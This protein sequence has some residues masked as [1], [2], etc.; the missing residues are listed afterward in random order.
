MLVSAILAIAQD[1]TMF[2]LTPAGGGLPSQAGNAGE[3]LTTNGTNASWL[4]LAGG[5][6]M[7]G[8]NN[9]S[10]I[11]S[12]S[13][14]RIE[15]GLVIGTNVQAWDA[16][17]DIYAGINPSANIQT[18]L[19]AA[20]YAAM[21]TQLGIAI[22]AS[23]FDGNLATTDDTIQEIAQKLDDLIAVGGGGGTWGSITGTLSAQTD[24]Q[25]ALD[26]K[27]PLDSDLTSIASLTTTTFGRGLLDEVDAT[28][29]RGTIG[30]DSLANFS[31]AIGTGGT[32]SGSTFLRG[33]NTWAVPAGA[34][35]VTATGGAL[36]L[37][38]IVLGAGGTDTKALAS[39]GTTTTVLHGNA[40]G[41]PSFGAVSL[42]AD[43][44]GDLPL[45]NLVQ[46]TALSVL[47]VTGNATA[48]NAPIVAALDGQILRRSG[49]TVGFG[50]IDLANADAVAGILPRSL[51]GLG[52]NTSAY[53]IGLFGINS[54]GGTIH[55]NTLALLDDAIGLTGTANS[56]TFLRGDGAWTAVTASAP[57]SDTQ[58]VFNDGGILG[59]DAG[60]LYN[61]TTD[62]ATFVN[63]SVTG[64]MTAATLDAVTFKVL[65]NVDQS[66]GVSIVA[67]ENLA[68]NVNLNLTLG[69]TR[70]LSIT[71]NSVLSG[72]NT[73]DQT[74]AGPLT[75]D[76]SGFDGNLA[77]TD[78]TVQEVAQ[79]L[80][81]LAAG[82]GGAPTT[83]N[84]LVGTADAGLSAAI[85]VGTTPGGELGG[86]W[87]SPT[88][89]DSLTVDLWTLTTPTLTTPRFADLGYIADAAGLELLVFDSVASAVNEARLGNAAT[90]SNPFL[91]A[92]G[93]DSNVGIDFLTKGDGT[94]RMLGNPTQS[95]RMKFLEDSDNGTNSITL[96]APAS[97]TTDSSIT[98]PEIAADTLVGKITTDVFQN[99][100]LS[101]ANNTL[102][103]Q[104]P[105]ACSD[106]TTA[107]TAGT[108]KAYWRPPH[109]CTIVAVEASAFTAPT[110]ANV[111]ID[112]NESGTTILSTKLMVEAT[113]KTSRTAVTPYVISDAAIADNAEVT[114][115]FDQVG[116]TVAGAGI[117]VTIIYT[118]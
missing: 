24:L 75:V 12:P 48:D 34:G 72:T 26:A 20:N 83:V 113:E 15:L 47:G 16:Q 28:S 40:A 78:N 14:A 37:N 52:A 93:G 39:L 54:G 65:D 115:D 22:D 64:A 84:Y 17:L 81:D 56:S 101:N 59:A 116:S 105:I 86:S 45:A 118:Y 112:I 103:Q 109:A 89:D 41:V 8:A 49:T 10:E 13:A 99:K 79:K 44:S 4:P 117:I 50:A 106:M 69:A 42:T 62:T 53:G 21:R 29:I 3:F 1:T 30:L 107:I 73:G 96:L 27:Q 97:I 76:A 77:T 60:A 70:S 57:G 110:G 87:A 108:N 80:D 88:I 32:P 7:V 6:D 98:L 74:A 2:P 102:P 33:D 90:G 46:G 19:G 61:K 23:G 111:L 25:A 95:G 67:N 114:I 51:G 66:H 43:V 58:F 5:G 100:D 55:V 31:T 94:V 36:T 85:V 9:L 18:F 104:Q 92:Q 68:S 63:L 35:T 11:T 82:G 38:A 91:A 71:G